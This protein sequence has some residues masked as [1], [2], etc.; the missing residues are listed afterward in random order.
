MTAMLHASGLGKRYE[1]R[2]VL[3]DVS[4]G[5]ERGDTL[6][7]IGP[8]GAGKTTLMRI[9]DLLDTPSSGVVYFDG[10][11]VTRRKRRRF[12][13]RRRMSFVQQKPVVFAMNVY[14]NVACGL[15]WRRE[16]TQD[17]RRKVDHVLELV[18]MSEHR[19]R[20]AETL[21]GGETQR[22]AIARALVTNPELLFLDE[23][24][25]NLDPMSTMR[26][27]QI[28]AGVAREQETAIVMATHDMSQGQRLAR[29]I[30]VLL[31]GRIRQVDT[32]NEVF[33]APESREVAEFVGVENILGGV[34][35]QKD[36]N[37]ATIDVVG[38][39][40]QA[41][42]DDAEGDGDLVLIRPEDVTFSLSRDVTSAR[43]VF[44]GTITRSTPVGPLVRIEMH[45]GFP[46]L[47]VVTRNSAENLHLSAGKTIHASFK[48]TAVHVIKRWH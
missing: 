33:C 47:G 12:E 2:D 28:L 29:R 14:E 37:M 6:A 19:D 9:L 22:V 48:A 15:R 40:I 5:I 4:L 23:P 32:P 35:I 45:C 13:A 30:A 8:S 7:V 18:D 38:H 3:K 11:D 10:V 25:A 24:T 42:S 44:K 43:N 34:V 20:R 17:I 27:E 26:I 21:S 16:G 36:D 31:N 41:V 46:L 39:A 1:D